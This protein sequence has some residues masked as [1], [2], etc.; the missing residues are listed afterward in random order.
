M[1]SSRP[2]TIFAFWT[3]WPAAPFIRLS[4]AQVAIA[5]FVRS[6][7]TTATWARLDPATLPVRGWVPCG[8][9]WTKRSPTV[10]NLVKPPELLKTHPVD[11]RQIDRGEQ[12][13]FEGGEMRR[14]DDRHVAGGKVCEVLGDLG[15][16]AMASHAVGLEVLVGHAVVRP[17]LCTPC[18]PRRRP[19]WRRPPRSRLPSEGPRQGRGRPPGSRPWDSTRGWPRGAACG[20]RPWQ[21]PAGRRGSAR[22]CSRPPARAALWRCGGHTTPRRPPGQKAGSRPRGR[23]PPRPPLRAGGQGREPP[24]GGRPKTQGHRPRRGRRRRGRASSM[25]QVPARPG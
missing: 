24:C 15:L 6:S 13:A 7:S 3:A 23:P 14:E 8:T 21:A 1:A 9:R 20:N 19:I 12:A 2:H 10:R 4:I 22:G 17:S 11:K 5:V 25:E 18:R 16:V